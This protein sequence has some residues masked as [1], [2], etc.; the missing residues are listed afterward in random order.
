MN[1]RTR[2]S[3]PAPLGGPLRGGPLGGSIWGYGT[4]GGYGTGAYGG[5]ETPKI[6]LMLQAVVTLGE[7]TTQGCIHQAVTI[8][9]FRYVEAFYRDS[10]LM[11][12]PNH[13]VQQ[14]SNW[15]LIAG[16]WGKVGEA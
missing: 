13:W 2:Q 8:P 15:V 10:G 7:K 14:G 16:H 12:Y 4:G 9:W 11:R 1:Q 6:E 3:G 5:G